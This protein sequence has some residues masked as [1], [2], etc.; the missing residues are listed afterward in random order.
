MM[1]KILQCY[2]SIIRSLVQVW[3]FII[4]PSGKNDTTD[5]YHLVISTPEMQLWLLCTISPGQWEQT[6]IISHKSTSLTCWVPGCDGF[7]WGRFRWMLSRLD[8]ERRL[9][10]PHR[11]L[12]PYFSANCHF[13]FLSTTYI[14]SDFFFF[15]HSRKFIHLKYQV[16]FVFFSCFFFLAYSIKVD[17]KPRRCTFKLSTNSDRLTFNFWSLSFWSIARHEHWVQSE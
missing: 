12:W 8:G 5:P 2:C 16:R 1:V 7:R 17:A 11:A 15:F 3:C 14:F 6:I 13:L 10:E 9:G 4:P